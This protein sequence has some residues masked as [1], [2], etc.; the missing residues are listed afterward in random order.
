MDKKGGRRRKLSTKDT[1]ELERRNALVVQLLL[2]E[3]EIRGL[4]LNQTAHS[5]GIS[6]SMLDKWRRADALVARSS[7]E[8]QDAVAAF[9]GVPTTFVL[10]LTGALTPKSF[11]FPTTETRPVAMGLEIS[12]AA[13]GESVEAARQREMLLRMA[14]MLAGKWE[15]ADVYETL[16]RDWLASEVWQD[17]P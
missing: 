4:T 17:R 6:Y 9:L 16:T 7:K 14:A 12:R 2:R 15:H 8:V 13:E 1:G 11:M 3:G 10:L 5:V